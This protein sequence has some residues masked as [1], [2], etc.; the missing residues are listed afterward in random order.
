MPGRDVPAYYWSHPGP[1]PLEG[2]GVLPSLRIA[3][4][5]WGEPAPDRGNAVVVFHALSGSSHAFATE[6]DPSPGWWQDLIGPSSP[7]D[8]SKH[9]LVCS[10]LIGGCYGTTG[11]GSIDPSTSK[12]YGARFPQ[13]L[14]GDMIEGQRALLRSLGID[15]PVTVIGGSL[16]GM[17]GLLWAIRYPEEVNRVIALVSAGRSYAQTIALRA[18]QREAIMLD[19]GWNGGDCYEGSFPEKGIGL[20]RKIGMITYRS[21]EE[22]EMRYGR[23]MRDPRPHFLEGKFEVQSYLDHQGNKFAGR[24]DPNTYLLFSRAMDLYDLSQGYSSLEEAVGRMRARTLLLAV[25]S[26]ILCPLYQVEELHAAISRT[27]GV[28]ELSVIHSVHGHDSFL[29]ETRK[30]LEA[31]S[32][33]FA[34]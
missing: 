14:T 9:F 29:K 16:G 23:Q 5:T 12:R 13:V 11:P 27:S 24:F 3:Y 33:F 21:A 7:L 18:V 15:R 22:F 10:N 6:A 31:L 34:A 28:S 8:P 19:P 20:A 17:L 4:E 2:G 1:F 32:R 25:D 30:V 26:D